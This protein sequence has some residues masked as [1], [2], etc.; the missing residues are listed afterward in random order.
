MRHLPSYN[1]N[2]NPKE[3]KIMSSRLKFL[4]EKNIIRIVE[5]PLK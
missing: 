3:K 4:K 1:N 2:T 5:S